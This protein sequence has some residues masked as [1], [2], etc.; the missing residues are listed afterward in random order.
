M[1]SGPAE[2][3]SKEL[4]ATGRVRIQL[5]AVLVCWATACPELIGSAR[6]HQ[7]LAAALDELSE[8]GMITLPAK[9]SW[10]RS[11][12]PPL[13]T[14]VTWPANRRQARPAPWRTF[15]WRPELGWAGSQPT[16]TDATFD[17]LVAVN[18][19]LGVRHEDGVVP[20]RVRSAEIFGDEKALDRLTTT[21]LFGPGRL[22]AE[23]LRCRRYPP[24]LVATKV[25]TGT[26]ALVVENS[27]AYWM[28]LHAAEADA[29]N[30]GVVAWGS[31]TSILQS[32][33]ALAELPGAVGKIQYWGDLDP[34]GISI[35]ARASTLAV[36]AGLPV[37]EPAVGL[38]SAMAACRP[39]TRTAV[40]WSASSAAWLGPEL[41]AATES[42]RVSGGRVA[43]EQVSPALVAEALHTRSPLA[44]EV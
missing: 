44:R 12:R 22:S 34:E 2:R 18:R 41:W 35:P 27:D 29:G 19:W 37:V 21:A 9:G 16:M 28:T 43:Q 26:T 15:A 20:M 36:S 38:W 13:P 3:L 40:D 33:S 17:A 14:F 30:I 39:Q 6:Q 4:G 1:L 10:D 8:L 7:G 24:P 25:G 42:V 32:I 5:S 31:G 11:T 23:L